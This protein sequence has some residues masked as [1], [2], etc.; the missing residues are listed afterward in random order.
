MPFKIELEFDFD[1]F[2][3]ESMLTANRSKIDITSENLRF[4]GIVFFVQQKKRIDGLRGR[5]WK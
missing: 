5:M 4:E 3:Q 2:L 1:G